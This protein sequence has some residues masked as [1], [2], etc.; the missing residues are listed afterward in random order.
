MCGLELAC[1]CRCSRCRVPLQ[2]AASGSCCQSGMCALEVACWCC[3]KVPL[4]GAAVRV[5]CACR[6]MRFG[7]GLLVPAGCCY[8]GVGML[9]LLQGAAVKVLCAL[10]LACWCRCKWCVRCGAGLPVPPLQGVAV[11][12]RCRML[13][14]GAAVRLL[15]ALWSWLA[16]ADPGCRAAAVYRCSV[17]VQGTTVKGPVCILG[18]WVML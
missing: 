11:V 12:C 13:R 8:S 2:S 3:C 10:E 5:T 15:C 17:R 1:W 7:A 4:Q 16:S 18:T 9:V 6:C 14:Q